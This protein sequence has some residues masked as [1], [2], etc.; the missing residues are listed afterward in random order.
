MTRTATTADVIVRSL[1]DHGVDTVFGLPGVQTYPLFDAMSRSG[2]RIIGARHEQTVAYMAFG[3]AQATGRTGVYSVVPGPGFLNS[4][5][6]LISAYGASAPVV[7][8]TG[9]IPSKF[10]GRGLGHLHELPDQLATIRS[11][12]KWAAT[13]E[14][15]GQASEL[16][17]QAFYHARQ[18]RPRP[19]A[20]AVP[21]DVLAAPAPAPAGAGAVRPIPVRTPEL[22]H[23][24][25]ARAARLLAGASNPMIMVGGGARDAAAQVRELSRRL[26]AP[27]VSFRG[28]GHRRRCRPVRLHLRRRLPALGGHR[29]AAR[30]RDPARACLVPLAGPARRAADGAHRHR[31]GAGG[32]A[33]A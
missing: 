5:A 33:R 4:S 14:H 24:A 32:Q 13:V 28:A 19:T 27:V 31:P 20:I 21:W 1:I 10:I 6:A 18:G 29:R 7:C 15:P 2:I 12:T 8:L 3:Y 17:A 25:V 23:A 9:E 26:Q 11:L 30:H 22:D 16:T